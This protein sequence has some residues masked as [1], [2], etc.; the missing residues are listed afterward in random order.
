M[1][2]AYDVNAV[3]NFLEAHRSDLAYTRKGTLARLLDEYNT[4]LTEPI[5]IFQ[6]KRAVGKF[7]KQRDCPIHYCPNK[8]YTPVLPSERKRNCHNSYVLDEDTSTQP[9]NP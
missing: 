8:Y 9:A 3:F 7:R 5:S 6:F 4:S 1:Q 2:P